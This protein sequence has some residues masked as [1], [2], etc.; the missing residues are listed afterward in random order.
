MDDA[1]VRL[2]AT[3]ESSEMV[4]YD[5]PLAELETWGVAF[6]LWTDWGYDYGKRLRPGQLWFLT[7]YA[8]MPHEGMMSGNFTHKMDAWLRSSGRT[9]LCY[10]RWLWIEGE[11]S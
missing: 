9:I 11:A 7:W 2:S 6:N 10:E 1:W 5:G 4:F 8:A 3:F